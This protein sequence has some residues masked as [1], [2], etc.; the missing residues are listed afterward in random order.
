MIEKSGIIPISYIFLM[1]GILIAQDKEQLIQKGD[2]CYENWEHRDA[3]IHY[4]N[5]LKIDSTDY[6]ILWRIS[7]AYTDLGEEAEEK[8][9]E[10]YYQHALDYADKALSA[11]HNGVEGHFRKAVALGRLALFK[12]GK[13]KIELSRGVKEQIDIVKKLD[14]EYDLAY[15]VIGRWHREIANLSRIL[16]ALAKM[17]Y[18]GVPEASNEKALENFKKAIELKP[19]YV[20]YRLELGRTY[21]MLEQ[22]EKAREQFAQCIELPPKEE[23]DEKFIKEAR[24]LLEDIKDK[25]LP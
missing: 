4:L 3:L 23:D 12:G 8:V 21:M 9:R 17:V 19:D 6:E 15:Y 16:K 24:E 10:P 18:G 2:D 20:E 7:R 25:K 22:W 1:C 14:P 11:N 13:T 5:A